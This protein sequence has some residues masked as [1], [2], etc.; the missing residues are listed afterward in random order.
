MLH[1]ISGVIRSDHVRNKAFP[2]GMGLHPLW[3]NWDGN[4]FDGHAILADGNSLSKIK[5]NIEVGEKRSKQRWLD[6][7]DFDL[8]VSRFHLEKAYN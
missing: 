5:V 8:T 4:V 3:K 7:L 6:R 1:W 2:I